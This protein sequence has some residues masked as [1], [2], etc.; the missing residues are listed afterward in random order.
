MTGTN[1]GASTAPT[2][3]PALKIPTAKARSRRGNH[4]AVVLTAAGKLPDS[5]KP[6]KNRAMPKPN[7]VRA[8][9][10]PAAARLHSTSATAY[11]MRV[12]TRSMKRPMMTKPMAYASVKAALMSPNW[13]SVQPTIFSSSGANTPNTARST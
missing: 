6:S 2:F 7:G 11:P 10:C 9:A 13:R 4:S 5:P 3:E 12:P 8:S 1:K